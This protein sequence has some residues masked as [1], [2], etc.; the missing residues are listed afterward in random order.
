ME[1]SP[2]RAIAPDVQMSRFSILMPRYR[3]LNVI[4]RR[5]MSS[6]ACQVSTPRSGLRALVIQTASTHVGGAPSGVCR[7]RSGRLL[8]TR[9]FFGIFNGSAPCSVSVERARRA[10][11]AVDLCPVRQ[12]TE[13]VNSTQPPESLARENAYLRQ[14]VAQLQDDV[15]AITAEAE[16]L[17]QIVER[18][19]GRTALRPPNPLS[20]GQ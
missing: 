4:A 6:T 10:C 9:R 18:L 8:P 1:G 13:A 20:G 19:H 3:R 5:G 2:S 12:G 16:R 15:T 17:R 7:H 11:P 14:R